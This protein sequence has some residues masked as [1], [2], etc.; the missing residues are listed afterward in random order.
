MGGQVADRRYARLNF[1]RVA[2]V[3]VHSESL[4][5]AEPAIHLALELPRVPGGG[6][7]RASRA[8]TKCISRSASCMSAGSRRAKYSAQA[9]E[10][11]ARAGRARPAA[12]RV[13][14]GIRS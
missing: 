5:D 10:S 9:A 8:A 2:D 12:L 6:V 4:V 1:C 11:S 13:R 3:H 14:H 7:Q